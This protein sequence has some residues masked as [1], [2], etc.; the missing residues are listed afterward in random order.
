[1]MKLFKK[2]KTDIQTRIYL[3]HGV[4]T[5]ADAQLRKIANYLSSKAQRIPEQKLARILIGACLVVAF[6]L[7]IRLFYSFNHRSGIKFQSIQIPLQ[8]PLHLSSVDENVLWRIKKFHHYLDS[9]KKND[10]SLY[11]SIMASRPHLMDS[12]ITIEEFTNQ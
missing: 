4:K 5:F 1:M 2:Q 6:A 9:L 12:I 7:G 8:K 3:F 11:D 10:L